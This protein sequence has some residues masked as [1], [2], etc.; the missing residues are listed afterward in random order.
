MKKLEESLFDKKTTLANF[1]S[2]LLKHF[3]VE[4]FHDTIKEVDDVLK[5]HKK[6]AC[7]LFDGAGKYNL[8]LYPHT[9]RFIL[10][11]ALTT[12]HSVNPATTVACT[13]SF[14][15][16]K[17]PIETGWMGWSL[18]FDEAG[19]PIDVFTNRYS[20]SQEKVGEDNYMNN[21][22][23]YKSIADLM[24]E[25]GVKASLMFHYPI[26]GEDGPKNTGEFLKR[27]SSFFKDGG[28]FLYGYFPEPDHTE[29]RYGVH[30]FHVRHKIAQEVRFLRR[31]VKKNPDVLVFS[32][33]DHG[34]LD[35]QYRNIAVYKEIE[36]SLAKPMSLEGRTASFFIKPG[37]E[38]IF[39]DSF[40]KHF[41]K[42]FAL[43]TKKE[44][45]D[46]HYFGEGEE[47][48]KAYSFIGDYLVI[49]TG[50]EYL[51][52]PTGRPEG[53]R[54]HVGHHAGATPM[55]REILLGVYNK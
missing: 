40:E 54:V 30:N 6:V 18:Q 53:G 34:L 31:F 37:R 21:R 39:V 20:I 16:G 32:F 36:E 46:S 38:K 7:F 19:G 33:A 10:G 11:H 23:P 9:T 51:C 5:G 29:H 26:N 28:E 27:A 48:E 24:N 22:F 35:V 47:N 8:G 15:S 1:S 43:L 17:F 49:A 2:S 42:S 50:N 14:L 12:I 3:G 4:P 13:T 41:G 44:V 45:I 52:D 25:R 55:E